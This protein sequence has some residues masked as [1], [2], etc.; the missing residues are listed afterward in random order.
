MKTAPRS[1][2]LGAS[3]FL[4]GAGDESWKQGA[5]EKGTGSSTLGRIFRKGIKV[6][7]IKLQN[8]I[9]KNFVHQNLK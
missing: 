6:S 9:R 5:G 3:S 2:E 1:Q 7:S 8:P 4:E